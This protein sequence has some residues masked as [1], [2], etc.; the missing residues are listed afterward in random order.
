[1]TT[2]TALDDMFDDA[3]RGLEWLE[4]LEALQARSASDQAAI[5]VA[6]YVMKLRTA[7]TEL[8]GDRSAA[9]LGE[10]VGSDTA[11]LV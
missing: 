3:E 10:S 6:E 11:A 4:K 5:E 7:V 1:M 8:A 2:S 9:D